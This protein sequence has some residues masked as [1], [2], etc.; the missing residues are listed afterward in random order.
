MEQN[1]LLFRISGNKIVV[2]R[3]RSS[4]QVFRIDP[5]CFLFLSDL[6]FFYGKH[7]TLNVSC[8]SELLKVYL[9]FHTKNTEPS[10]PINQLLT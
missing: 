1:A 6:H 4:N 3:T 9:M 7:E 5:N 10:T 2:C 8:V